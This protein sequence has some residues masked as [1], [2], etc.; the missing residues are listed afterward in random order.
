MAVL[1]RIATT[2][3][4]ITRGVDATI[5]C[6]F[7]GLLVFFCSLATLWAIGSWNHIGGD[8]CDVG[9]LHPIVVKVCGITKINLPFHCW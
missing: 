5:F 4:T 1:S 2:M 7:F 3:S 9:P 8:I 6:L